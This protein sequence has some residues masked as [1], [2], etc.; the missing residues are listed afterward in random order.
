M[1]ILLARLSFNANI[2]HRSSNAALSSVAL[3]TISMNGSIVPY[4]ELKLVN[5]CHNGYNEINTSYKHNF[6][7]SSFICT[8]I[9]FR[10]S[11]CLALTSIDAF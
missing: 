4:G 3:S 11:G 5:L 7:N 1:K 6:K 10:C 9:V 8:G 2:G